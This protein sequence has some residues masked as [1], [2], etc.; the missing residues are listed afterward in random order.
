MRRK[1]VERERGG[2][3]GSDEAVTMRDIK[4]GSSVYGRE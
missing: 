1:T 4:E 3:E 2:G